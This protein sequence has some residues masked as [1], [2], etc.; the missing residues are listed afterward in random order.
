[1]RRAQSSYARWSS[2][3]WSKNGVFRS[4]STWTQ[5]SAAARARTATR[6]HGEL[7]MRP[8]A[9]RAARPTTAPQLVG[10][11]DL[12]ADDAGSGHYADV[13]TSADLPLHQA[14]GEADLPGQRDDAPL[15]DRVA[16][17]GATAAT[18]RR[19]IFLDV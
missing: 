8:A 13:A 10:G 19:D 3:R 14:G 4:A 15:N 12:L 7:R 2:T 16:A 9:E 5:R 11:A 18:R 6:N 17:V 1:M